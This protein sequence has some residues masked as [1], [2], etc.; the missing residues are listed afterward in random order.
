MGGG[1]AALM[2]SEEQSDEESVNG[3][4]TS[5]DALLSGKAALMGGGKAALM[6]EHPKLE[7][8][9]D[10]ESED[11]SKS[12]PGERTLEAQCMRNALRRR[13]RTQ[14]W[15]AATQSSC[16]YRAVLVS[17]RTALSTKYA[18]LVYAY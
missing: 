10:P 7:L 18:S 8:D 16:R 1:K 2:G 13:S 14:P 3:L 5:K 17:P 6:G 15:Q 12:G 4:A 9:E 11:H